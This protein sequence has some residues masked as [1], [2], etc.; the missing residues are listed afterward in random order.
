MFSCMLKYIC[1]LLQKIQFRT[2][3]HIIKIGCVF[4]SLNSIQLEMLPITRRRLCSQ[5]QTVSIF[6]NPRI[7]NEVEQYHI[8]YIDPSVK[9]K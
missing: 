3:Y 2:P 5:P 6:E 4:K 9:W 1:T 7:C 8:R